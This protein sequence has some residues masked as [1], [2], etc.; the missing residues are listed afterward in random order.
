M[1]R[2]YLDHAASTPMHPQVAEAMMK[3][4]TGQYGNASSIH[5]FGRDAKRTVS[6]AR[7]SI[8][9][10]LN[11][12]P[13]ELVFTSGGTESDNLA[14][15]G[16]VSARK[17][18]GK[19]V[20]TTVIE[21][22]AVLHSCQE[23]E[24]QGYEV[25]YLSVDEHG[26]ISFDEL[27][28]AIRPD[29]VLITMM[30]ANNEVGT[31]QPIR[32]IGE[33]ARKHQILFH[34]DAVQAL[35]TQ[36]ISCKDLPVDLIS[37]SAHKING[38]Q[39]VGALY[40]RRGIVLEAKSHG[41]LQE[42]QRRAGTENIAGIAGFAEALKIATAQAETHRQHD[43][44]LRQLLLK[45]LEIHVGQEHFH[46]NGHPEYTLPNILNISFPEVSTETML[47]NLDME[48][49]AVAS[50][51]ACTSGSLEVSHVLKAMMLPEAFL[52]SAIR[53]SWGLGNT[54]EEIMKTAEKIGT[55]LER[56]RNRP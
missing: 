5:S 50:G 16:A 36:N 21:H 8:A 46:V 47:M 48:G 39:G 4:M 14:I 28:E 40:V 44:E 52:H 26:R 18:Q 31:I 37:F 24:R 3:V 34:T 55:I 35:G 33:L 17:E 1:N 10:S 29:T 54:T 42:R 23:L 9:A 27:Q 22:H 15:F 11:C 41:G 7:D 12:F 13:D 19:H 20:I 6:G 51:S 53:F 2:I 49:I 38:P 43:L 56:L 45:Q 30:F 25:T 32:E